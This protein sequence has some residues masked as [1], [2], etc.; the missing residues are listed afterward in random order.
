MPL[1]FNT[2]CYI[3]HNFTVKANILSS[4]TISYEMTTKNGT[5]DV[6]LILSNRGHDGWHVNQRVICWTIRETERNGWSCTNN[7]IQSE[8][9]IVHF[10]NNLKWLYGYLILSHG[11]LYNSKNKTIS[12]EKNPTRLDN[13]STVI[14][15]APILIFTDTPITDIS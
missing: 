5:L 14:R 6:Q 3:A 13:F 7:L 10:T 2:Y 1:C 9:Q 4:S 12:I 11:I 8:N 15:D